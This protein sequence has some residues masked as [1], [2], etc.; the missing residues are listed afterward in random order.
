[1]GLLRLA[2]VMVKLRMF[3]PQGLYRLLST[4]F[5]YGINVMALLNIAQ[6]TYGAAPALVDDH[7]EW[8]YRQLFSESERLAQ[9]LQQRYQLGSGRKVGLL[10]SNHAAL[11][12][13]LFAV[14]Q[15]GA[16]IYLLNVEMSVE[17]LHALQQEHGF[18]LV[19]HDAQWAAPLEQSPYTKAVL[20][21]YHERL[22][23]INNLHLHTASDTNSRV[24]R[25]STSRFMLLTGGTTG[26]A[27]RVPHKPSLFHYLNPLATMLTRMRLT[28][29]SVAYIATPIYH[30]YG[31]A[32]LL[33]WTA[34]GKK[35]VLTQRFDA[36]K[37]CCLIREQGVE[38]VTVV[39]L[40]LDKMLK[41]DAASLRS[42]A[43]IASGGDK[44]RPG[45]AAEVA[46]RLGAVLYN[47]YGTSEA[48]LV[49]IATP[50]EL[51]RDAGTIGR[52]IQGLRLRIRTEEGQEA[53]AGRD[54]PLHV[55]SRRWRRRIGSEEGQEAEAGRIGPLHVSST[56]W[57]RLGRDAHWIATGDLAYRDGQG[58]YYLCGRVD[59]LVVS[60]GENVYPIELERILLQHPAVEDAAVIGVADEQ[61]G[62]RL[63]AY[64]QA[65]AGAGLTAAELLDWLR[66][67]VA[68]YQMP[69]EIAFLRQMPYT[70][71]GKQD[72]KQLH[73]Q[74]QS[75]VTS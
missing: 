68:R 9:I 40:M 43:C 56:N 58:Y 25:T 15:T 38:V 53:E 13:S 63:K 39:P 54:A 19:I 47:L 61:F 32:I 23:A 50:Q 28:R 16:D 31:L 30:G 11:V 73:N 57:W 42:L 7:G 51:E 45:L 29:Y 8:S 4:M 27:K 36:A 34:L 33:L 37:A 69:R 49:S 66:P 75:H 67:R 52:G 59:D 17:G 72:K 2:E 6:R 14:S 64:V 26:K 71:L 65:D 12:K 55:S 20:H 18:D 22:P 46:E 60:A 5:R 70:H 24:R 41:Q 1:M 3:T 35:M 10:C 21:S 44:L 74:L 62:Q 48:G